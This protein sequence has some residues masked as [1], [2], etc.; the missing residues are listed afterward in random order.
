MFTVKLFSLHHQECILK[1]LEEQND[2]G[3]PGQLNFPYVC[4]VKLRLTVKTFGKRYRTS[5]FLLPFLS[6]KEKERST[7][8]LQRSLQASRLC[9]KMKKKATNPRSKQT[10]T[11]D[12][13]SHPNHL[14]QITLHFESNVNTYVSVHN[15]SSP[16]RIVVSLNIYQV[17]HRSLAGM[18]FQCR[19]PKQHCL[20]KLYE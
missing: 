4:L 1:H 10:V 14:A 16:S 9:D 20:I 13:Q 5:V 7:H 12:P 2:N 17:G 11:K 15:P 19:Q 6:S 18:N 3:V 8:P